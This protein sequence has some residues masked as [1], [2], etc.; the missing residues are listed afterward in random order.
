[1]RYVEIIEYGEADKLNLRSRTEGLVPGS[2]QVLVEVKAASYNPVDTELRKGTFDPISARSF[3][4]SQGQDWSGVVIAVGG[5]VSDW[6]I[7][8]E[9]YGCQPAAEIHDDG[10]W[11]EKMRVDVDHMAKKPINLTWEEAAGL[12]LVGMT[13]LQALRDEGGL[14]PGKGMRVFING[15]SGGV[16]H[17]AVQIARSLGAAYIVGTASAQHHLLLKQLGADE[18][19]DY[20]TFN[21]EKYQGQFDI[22]FDA[23]AKLDYPSVEHLLSEEGTYIRTRPSVKTAAAQAMTKAASMMGFEKRAKVIWMTPNTADLTY[24]TSLVQQGKLSVLVAETYP[25]EK[26][27]QF[28]EAGEASHKAGKYILKM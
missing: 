11:A 8:D 6:K 25:L 15:A 9:V 21:P 2:H 26:Y 17:T 18:A 24:L 1:M 10:S 3:P 28:V 16:G 20:R 13:S 4:Q 12:P 14:K 5:G 22:F 7:G 23:A 27:R 19:L